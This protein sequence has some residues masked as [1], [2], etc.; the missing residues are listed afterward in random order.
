LEGLQLGARRRP[1][2]GVQIAQALEAAHAQHILPRKVSRESILVR[3]QDKLAKLGDMI[4]AKALEGI[5]ARQII[6]PGELV[7][8]AASR[9]PERTPSDVEA[10][11][12]V[13]TIAQIRQSR[14]S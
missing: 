9:S 8:N 12:L 4:L 11:S 13:E 2:V 3:N 5:K 14:T 7:G 1:A 6:R 10:K